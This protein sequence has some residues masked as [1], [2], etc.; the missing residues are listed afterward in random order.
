VDDEPRILDGLRD[1]LR[2]HRKKW[3]MVFAVGGE[4][5]IRELDAAPFDVLVTDA[6]MPHVDGIAVLKHARAKHPE[7][8]RIVL[9]GEPGEN[10][11]L[12]IS[13]H[14]HQSLAKPCALADLERTLTRACQLRELVS[15]AD[16]RN[17]L[18]QIAEFP[19]LPKTYTK[20]LALLEDEQAGMLDVCHVVETDLALSVKL[21]QLVNS[22]FFGVGRPV[23]TLLQA[24]QLLGIDLV[25]TLAL[26]VGAL[27]PDGVAPDKL[28]ILEALNQHAADVAHVA[29]A[30]APANRRRSVF[31][32]GLLHDLGVLVLLRCAPERVAATGADDLGR[33]EDHLHSS[34]GAYVLGLW[35]LPLD[36][37][38][39]VAMHHAPLTPESSTMVRTIASAEAAIAAARQEV[40]G[41]DNAAMVARAIA[42]A[43]ET[44]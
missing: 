15:D 1:V 14:A 17:V 31:T 21:L 44:S 39:A 41:R 35:G 2:K 4:A 10:L 16:L 43:Q 37:V 19:A 24:V 11:V 3:D 28:R 29:C 25:K 36:L 30:I 8:V 32:A 42:I 38:E 34:L 18:G 5:A 33:T 26:S 9:S 22:A 7:T 23:H 27:S 20:L 6:K 40:S 12:R 13:P